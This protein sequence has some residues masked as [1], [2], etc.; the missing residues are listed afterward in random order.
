VAFHAKKE[1]LM[2]KYR[3][4]ITPFIQYALACLL[5]PAIFIIYLVT[6][7]SDGFRLEST[8]RVFT[9]EGVVLTPHG[10][11]DSPLRQ[12]DILV[13]INGVSI[14]ER[15]RTFFTGDARSRID[16][17]G[18]P[19]LYSV[20]RNGEFL[21]VEV[22]LGPFPW[23]KV[24][25]NHWGVFLF[26]LSTQGV[27]T[28]ILLQRR[29]D[30]AAQAFFI[31][32]FSG[33]HTYIWAFGLQTAD[34]LYG[35][36]YWYFRLVNVF[37]W[38]MFW[39]AMVHMLLVFPR[40]LL[41]VRRFSI[42]ILGV[43]A[44]PFLV[45]GLYLAWDYS[46]SSSLLTW[47]NSIL[48]GE[49]LAAIIY[50]ILGIVLFAY[51]YLTAKSE[52]DRIKIGWVALGGMNSLI[53]GLVLFILPN[54]I[55]GEP[56]LSPNGLGLVN[57]PF[58]IALAI[59]IWKYSLF[60]INLVIR[61]TVIYSILTA[62]LAFFYFSLVTLLQ[63]GISLLEGEQSSVV[64]VISTLA[65]AAL[66]NPLRK[67]IQ[68]FIDRRYFRRRYNAEKSL[69]DFSE[70]ASRETD[71]EQLAEHVTSMVSDTLQPKR[72]DLWLRPHKKD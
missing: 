39:P 40:I 6:S 68:N 62:S 28:F 16:G 3:N 49:Y 23:Q 42:W 60:D 35:P 38:L 11:S 33:S 19:L 14:E 47:W 70:A 29:R 32:A 50:M 66:F 48:I 5:M 52:A 1:A 45:F 54:L 43:Y 7:P 41:G 12:G 17:A 9:P 44:L 30:P 8:T 72:I 46:R 15:S 2:E 69:A 58:I 31:W 34:L 55:L 10:E 22:D 4:S 20:L 24:L 25:A 13:A 71:L 63:M 18:S 36:S 57:F 26:I 67:S 61:S 21:Q 65:I 56:F 51:Q 53:L 64:V 37:L 27:A 59:A